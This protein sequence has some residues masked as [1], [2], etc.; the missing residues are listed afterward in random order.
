VN[1]A[2]DVLRQML[3]ERIL[4]LDGA[5]G[6]MIQSFKLG[7]A[8]FR[9]DRFAGF[10]SPL[11]SNYDLLSLT[12]P[13]IIE[14]IHKQYLEAG[15]DII[16]TNT[17]GANS[18]S[19]EGYKTENLVYELNVS[20]AGIARHTVEQAMIVNPARSRF[21]AGAIGPTNRSV[22]LPADVKCPGI[23][24][25][26]SDQ[27]V[28]AYC[29]QVN[30]LIDGGVDLL[31]V[32]S[33]YD[34]LNGK[35]ALQAIEKCFAERS[36]RIP[37]MISETID[38]SGKNLSGHTVET[39]WKIVSGTELLCVGFNCSF[40][41][42]EM[43]SYIEQLSNLVP[44]YTICYPNAGLPD[45]AGKYSQTPEE[46]AAVLKEFAANGWLNIV[47]GCCGTTPAHIQAIAETV[48]PFKPRIP[49]QN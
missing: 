14:S 48:R 27:L 49:S 4:I 43:R 3:K 31:L 30:G 18:Y 1:Q 33:V 16:E 45:A 15:A 23:N 9:G 24:S 37:V 2:A 26:T 11:L 35:A 20:A 8:D 5:M 42:H 36:I 44:A 29:T 19:Q 41:A 38:L 34:T 13:H 46:M 12:Q 17:F 7:E 28:S 40:G 22:S 47:G 21:V 6:T 10:S 32:E 25:I 39:F